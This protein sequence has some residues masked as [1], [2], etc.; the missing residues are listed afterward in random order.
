[1]FLGALSSD[2]A[3]LSRIVSF[4]GFRYK[5]IQFLIMPIW[6]VHSYVMFRHFCLFITH[7]WHL[8]AQNLSSMQ[9]ISF[10]NMCCKGSLFIRTAIS[11]TTAIFH[12][13]IF[14]CWASPCP[15]FRTFSVPWFVVTSV[16]FVHNFVV[17]S[18]TCALLKA[19]FN[20]DV[21]VSVSAKN[22]VLLALLAQ[23]V[24]RLSQI[25]D[26]SKH[27]RSCSTWGVLWFVPQSSLRQ[28]RSFF[29]SEYCTERDLMLHLTVSVIHALH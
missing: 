4:V 23:R 22:V 13:Y 11:L 9:Y 18:H 7:M 15:D 17:T 21:V 5:N 29:Q 3:C 6:N 12:R 10:H 8:S 28:V 19:M 25:P 20:S 26:R 1:M 24:R 27:E 2:R 16:C 14:L